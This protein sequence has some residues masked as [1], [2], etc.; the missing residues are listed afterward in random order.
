MLC[1]TEI[2]QVD[3]QECC[4][5]VFVLVMLPQWPILSKAVICLLTAIFVP[6][7]R[8]VFHLIELWLYILNRWTLIIVLILISHV[9]KC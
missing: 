8:F 2:E 4:G 1:V 3:T 9:W 6:T 5:L 7:W